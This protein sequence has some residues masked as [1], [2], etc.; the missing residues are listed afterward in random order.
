[1][2][3]NRIM[4]KKAFTLIEVALTIFLV[5]VISTLGYFYLNTD[6]LKRSQYKTAIQSQINLIESMVFQCKSL[7][8]QM[9]NQVGGADAS[10]TNLTSLECNTST[11]YAFDG[12]RNGFVPVPPTGFTAYTATETGTEFYIMTTAENN[13][14]QDEALVSL[15]LNYTS[16]QA[17]LDHNATSATFKFYLSR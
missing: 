16:T 4:Q 7:S 10:D 3:N 17:T 9:P 13:S 12:G 14:T 2:S 8:E 1:M 11:P 15:A 6:N 5:G